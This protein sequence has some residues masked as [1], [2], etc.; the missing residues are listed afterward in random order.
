MSFHSVVDPTV[1]F[2]PEDPWYLAIAKPRMENTA[3]LHLG[4]QGMRTC[5][6]L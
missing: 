6:P 4:R 1:A 2:S 5:L 3:L